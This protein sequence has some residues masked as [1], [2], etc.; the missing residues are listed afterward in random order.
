M[1]NHNACT[2]WTFSASTVALAPNN[3]IDDRIT[4]RI[5]TSESD[6][7][8][9]RFRPF[10]LNIDPA[11]RIDELKL[12]VTAPTIAAS[13]RM[14]MTGGTASAKSIGSVSDGLRRRRPSVTA[15]HG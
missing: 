11:D 9:S 6:G 8:A 13:P 2:L 15:G 5:R 7:H 1:K 10:Q 3:R 12:D 4:C 14:P